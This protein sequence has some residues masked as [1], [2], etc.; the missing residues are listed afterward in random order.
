MKGTSEVW[1][2][3]TTGITPPVYI[4]RTQPKLKESSLAH[5]EPHP[6]QC[7]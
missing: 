5:V 4:G 7:C 1:Q 6:K 3:R 2:T